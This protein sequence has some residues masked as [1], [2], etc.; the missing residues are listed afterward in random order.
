LLHSVP[1]VV[2]SLLL[3]LKLFWNDLN[4][5]TWKLKRGVIGY[6]PDRLCKSDYSFES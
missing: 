3:I 2:D 5:Q 1:G 4:F 6:H